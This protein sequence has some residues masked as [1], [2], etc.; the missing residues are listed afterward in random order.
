MVRENE[1][2]EWEVLKGP[3]CAV[4]GGNRKEMETIDP[5]AELTA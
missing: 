1:E 2:W 3:G 5:N 4:G